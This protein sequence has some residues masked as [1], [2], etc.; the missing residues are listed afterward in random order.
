M[1]FGGHPGILITV[2]PG[3]IA[4]SDLAPVGLPPEAGTPPHAEQ[5]PIA[6]IAAAR[7]QRLL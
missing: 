3:K 6:I 4:S 2:L 7:L 1:G 5:E